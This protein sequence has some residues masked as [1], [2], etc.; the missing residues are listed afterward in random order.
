[1][2]GWHWLDMGWH[3][4][5]QTRL[6]LYIYA[7][8]AQGMWLCSAH[9][10]IWCIRSDLSAILQSI[11]LIPAILPATIF[12]IYRFHFTF[13]ILPIIDY[14]CSLKDSFINVQCQR[15]CTPVEL[16]K[17]LNHPFQFYEAYQL[18]NYKTE[19]LS[20][21]LDHLVNIF[22]FSVIKGLLVSK[23]QSTDNRLAFHCW[24]SAEVLMPNF[25]QL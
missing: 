1:M 7:I 4:S 18:F 24:R 10:C 3:P 19:N 23:R 14:N 5:R 16:R 8:K 20:K 12:V 17:Y 13:T 21:I 22:R 6:R 25:I 2:D 15:L 11:F 9:F